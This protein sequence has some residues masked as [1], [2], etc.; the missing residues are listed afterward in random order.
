MRKYVFGALVLTL[1]IASAAAAALW[2]A[3]RVP[4]PIAYPHKTHVVDNQMECLTC[5][6]NA[7]R[8]IAA[9]IPSVTECM[10]CHENVKVESPEIQKL[11]AYA[12]A[13]EEPPWVRAYGFHPEAAVY[14]THKRH[15][16][17]GI[18]CS[19]CHGDMANM[20]DMR[21]NIKWTMGKC[22]DCHQE[23]QVSVDCLVCHK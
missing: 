11:A 17:A 3:R 9:T 16:K 10:V 7:D 2:P 21:E 15:V 12:K 4:Q 23:K 1:L 14:F 8:S 22:I 20:M 5:H 18:E 6:V 19:T 13:G